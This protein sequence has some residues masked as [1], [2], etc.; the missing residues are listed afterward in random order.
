MARELATLLKG[1]GLNVLN[2][3]VLNQVVVQGRTDHETTA[4]RL[5]VEK[6]G[7]AWFGPTVWKGSAAFRISISSWRTEKADIDRLFL[8]IVKARDDVQAIK[9]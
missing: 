6:S 5:A 1:A 8:A 4:I 9:P 3:V 7:E 2:R